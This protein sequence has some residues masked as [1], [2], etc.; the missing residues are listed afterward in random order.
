MLFKNLLHSQWCSIVNWLVT[1]VISS[2]FGHIWDL[3]TPQNHFWKQAVLSR[4]VVSDSAIPWT[5]AHQVPLSL[6]ILQ[7]KILEWVAIPFSRAS[8]QSRGQT[9]VSRIAGKFFT[10]WTTREAQEYWDE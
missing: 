2:H 5:A 3:Q 9:Q 4:S 10:D 7:A 6:G 8:T 1:S